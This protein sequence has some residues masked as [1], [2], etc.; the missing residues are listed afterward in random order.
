MVEILTPLCV[1]TCSRDKTI[2]LFDIEHREH[3]R[4]I[5]EHHDTPIRHLRYQHTN[6]PQMVSISS[7]IEANVWAPESLVSDIHVGKLVGH[8]K[9]IIDGQYLAKAPYFVTIDETNLV[10]FWDITNL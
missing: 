7:D 4:T 8:K 2:V 9:Q 5:K 6:G 3:L 1:A 10:C